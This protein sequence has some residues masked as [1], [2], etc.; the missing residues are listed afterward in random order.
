M[1]TSEG[2]SIRKTDQH[3]HKYLDAM[4]EWIS[5]WSQVGFERDDYA[6]DVECPVGYFERHGKRILICD[7]QGY[8][9]VNKYHDERGAQ[10][11]FHALERYYD[12]WDD[13][14]FGDEAL[15]ELRQIDLNRCDRFIGYVA[16]NEVHNL[17][18]FEF[19]VWVSMGEP[20]G[21]LG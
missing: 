13:E 16:R 7:D 9:W 6:G 14:A 20:K 15:I 19:D 10:A 11:M 21:Y 1:I 3:R 4:A 5:Y 8:V 2:V 12:T 17:E 18:S